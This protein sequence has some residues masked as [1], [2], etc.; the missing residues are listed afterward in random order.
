MPTLACER[1][2]LP[3][4]DPYGSY[5]DLANHYPIARERRSHLP[6]WISEIANELGASPR[7]L[8]LAR[9]IIS[10]L[11]QGFHR[12][13]GGYLYLASLVVASRILGSPLT[14]KTISQAAASVGLRVSP[15]KLAIVVGEVSPACKSPATEGRAVRQYISSIISRLKRDPGLQSALCYLFGEHWD[16]ALD[17]LHVKSLELLKVAAKVTRSE[18]VGKSPAVTAAATVWLAAKTLGLRFITQE[19]VARA[20]GVSSSALRRRTKLL[21]QGLEAAR[22]A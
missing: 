12:R 18:L 7:L 6:R 16:V 8:E 22:V 5:S 1:Q 17:R 20:A 19:R 21:L 11:P 9:A 2:L 4:V 10:G 3:Y 14:L 13:R 15:K